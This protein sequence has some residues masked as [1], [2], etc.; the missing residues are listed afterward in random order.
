MMNKKL[1]R[2]ALK[3]VI[4]YNLCFKCETRKE[5]KAMNT[6]DFSDLTRR[7][8]EFYE[9]HLKSQLEPEHNGEFV[10]I[11]PD[12]GR[13]FLDKDST[14]VVIKARA[15]MPDKLFYFGRV[16]YKCAHKIRGSRFKVVSK[17]STVKVTK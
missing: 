1:L 13:Y 12:S 17:S 8:I 10:A 7:G 9:K 16:G 11:E 2:V 15:E 5:K 4:N 14:Q 3:F 6:K